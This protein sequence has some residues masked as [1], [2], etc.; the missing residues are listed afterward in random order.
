MSN[1]ILNTNL[2]QEDQEEK[3]KHMRAIDWLSD[4]K[5]KKKEKKNDDKKDDDKKDDDK[6]DDDKKGDE[7]KK[8]NEDKKKEDKKEDDEDTQEDGEE[9]DENATKQKYLFRNTVS[10]LMSALC[11]SLSLGIN[12]IFLLYLNKGGENSKNKS[13]IFSL[14]YV[15]VLFLI[16]I[17]L[18]YYLN[19]S[20]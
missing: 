1:I 19:I 14:K 3:P 7:D 11:L 13:I 12:E 10:I 6:K 17:G 16:T 20:L 4:K 8:K 2:K 18:S 5:K 9:E 15:V